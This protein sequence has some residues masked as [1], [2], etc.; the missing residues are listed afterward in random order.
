MDKN[1]VFS[2]SYSAIESKEVQNI[3]NK[4]LPNEENKLEEL[5]KLDSRVQ[6][7]GVVEALTIGITGCLIFGVSMC[8]GLGAIRGGIILAVIL[9]ILGIAAMLPAYFVY[10]T[11]Q[12]AAKEKYASR[13]LELAEEIEFENNKFKIER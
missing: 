7:S 13:I 8:I 12:N 9:G 4:Y 11:K 5:R 2:Y 10:R 3:R 1:T 6:S